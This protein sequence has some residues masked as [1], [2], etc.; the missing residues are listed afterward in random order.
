MI[1]LFY[2]DQGKLQLYK[3]E[4]MGNVLKTAYKLHELKKLHL[5]SMDVDGERYT[6]SDILKLIEVEE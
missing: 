1:E 3:N 4:N 2:W 5:E 6:R